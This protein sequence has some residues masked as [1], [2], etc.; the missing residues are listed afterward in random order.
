MLLQRDHTSLDPFGTGTRVGLSSLQA[1]LPVAGRPWTLVAATATPHE[2]MSEVLHDL[3]LGVVSSFEILDAADTA[4]PVAPDPDDGPAA[5]DYTPVQPP[6]A[7]GIE[8]GFGT[9]RAHRVEGDT[10]RPAQ[11]DTMPDND[12]PGDAG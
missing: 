11:G 10:A 7:P 6:A 1:F 3:V 5:A 12:V 9:L 8:R 4:S 2:A